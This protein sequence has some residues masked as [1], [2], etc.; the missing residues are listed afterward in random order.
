MQGQTRL[1]LLHDS[2]TEEQVR[3]FLT[4]VHELY[5]KVLLNPLYVEGSPI[6]APGWDSRVRQLAKRTLGL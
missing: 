2:R 4:E 5:V 1:M 3:Q 6:V